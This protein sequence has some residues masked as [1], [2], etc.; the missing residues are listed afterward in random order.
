MTM[1]DLGAFLVKV[2]ALGVGVKGREEG[3]IL[4]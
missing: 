3:R 1:T 2:T 4:D